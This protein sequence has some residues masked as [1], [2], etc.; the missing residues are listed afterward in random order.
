MPCMHR[1]IAPLSTQ[2]GSNVSRYCRKWYI[3]CWLLLYGVHILYRAIQKRLL[4]VA[5]WKP[6]RTT[7]YIVILKWRASIRFKMSVVHWRFSLED[8]CWCVGAGSDGVRGRRWRRGRWNCRG[9]RRG[10][11][12]C[13]AAPIRTSHSGYRGYVIELLILFICFI[14]SRTSAGNLFKICVALLWHRAKS[15]MYR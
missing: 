6:R 11:S 5:G 14:D 9:A 2:F 7:E 12:A 15:I 4:F 10:A 8:S 13:T 1:L 3:L